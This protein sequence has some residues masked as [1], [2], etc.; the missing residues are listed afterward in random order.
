MHDFFSNMPPDMLVR[1]VHE[2]QAEIRDEVERARLS[3]R[4][5]GAR[6]SAQIARILRR[7][8]G[9]APLAAYPAPDRLRSG[10]RRPGG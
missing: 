2:R 6:K 1:Y 10:Q 5:A 4:P 3:A 8:P 7:L 9:A